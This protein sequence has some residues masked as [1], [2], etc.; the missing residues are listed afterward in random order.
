MFPCQVEEK[1]ETIRGLEDDLLR[2]LEEKLLE[3]SQIMDPDVIAEL[4]RELELANSKADVSL[5]FLLYMYT[6]DCS[7]SEVLYSAIPKG[8]TINHVVTM[9][10]YTTYTCTCVCTMYMTIYYPVCCARETC[11]GRRAQEGTGSL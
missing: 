9:V 11:D 5:A 10:V 8:L 1:S 3:K 6:I 2:E 7:E 4:G